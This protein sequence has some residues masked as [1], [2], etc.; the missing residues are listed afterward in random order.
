MKT[1][2][3]RGTSMAFTLIELLVATV[4]F[5]IL[6]FLFI[7]IVAATTTVYQGGRSHADN[8]ATGRVVMGAIARDLSEMIRL[9]EVGAF[10]T[11]SGSHALAGYLNRAGMDSGSEVRNLSLVEYSFDS[12]EAKLVRSDLAIKWDELGKI[13]FGQSPSTIPQLANATP[14]E[15]CSGVMAFDYDFLLEDGSFQQS[16]ADKKNVKAV[17]YGLVIVSERGERILRDTGKFDSFVSEMKL[18]GTPSSGESL[19]SRW[20]EKLAD[21]SFTAN[22]SSEVLRDVEVFE[23]CVVLPPEE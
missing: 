15:V 6:L 17:R 12:S 1:L 16:F 5:S 2:P 11:A 8:N 3:K 9:S 21:S 13:A 4:I 22:Y 19:K 23:H 10:P 7:N 18:S 20:S 14:R